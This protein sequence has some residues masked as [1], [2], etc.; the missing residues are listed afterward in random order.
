MGKISNVNEYFTSGC[1]RCKLFDTPQCKVQIWKKELTALRHIILECGLAEELKWSHPCYTF[2]GS[3]VI[4]L[5]AFNDY[6]LIS[7]IKGVLLKDEQNILV[8]Q[9]ENVQSGRVIK[10]TDVK[11]I[12][13]LEKTLKAYIY[14]AIE[15]EKAGLK[16]ELKKTSEFKM[17]EELQAKFKKTP[18]FKKAFEALTP[19][20]QRGYILYFSQAKQSKTREERIEKSVPKILQGKG[21][22]D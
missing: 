4:L 14:E 19:G 17:P 13:K 3:N 11:D 1:G 8:A 6:C 18:A 2:Q 20:R 5:G 12:L 10:F 15:I 21:L 16:V 22:Q 9:T 7:F